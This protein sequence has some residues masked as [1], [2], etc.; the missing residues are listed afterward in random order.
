[1]E[2]YRGKLLFLSS[3]TRL[4]KFL[5]KDGVLFRQTPL[6]GP[7]VICASPWQLAPSSDLPLQTSI[8]PLVLEVIVLLEIQVIHDR[9]C[10]KH[11]LLLLI[12]ALS[13]SP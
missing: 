2:K 8:H 5:D 11:H 4:G 1:M 6:E 9:F 7:S 3:L 12:A 10:L 13:P